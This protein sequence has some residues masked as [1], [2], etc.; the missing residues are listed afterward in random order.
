MV[1]ILDGSSK[2]KKEKPRLVYSSNLFVSECG[3]PLFFMASWETLS[4]NSIALLFFSR[5][6]VADRFG[7]PRT[8]ALPHRLTRVP[9]QNFLS[10]TSISGGDTGIIARKQWS[11]TF[12]S[13]LSSYRIPAQTVHKKT[14]CCCTR[15]R[16]ILLVPPAD[17]S[18]AC[19]MW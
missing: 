14:T 1:C 6:T 16:K 2:K 5:D 4:Q 8:R 11:S 13:E 17:A 3:M 7:A 18:P 19:S 10:G 12:P 9:G 15:H